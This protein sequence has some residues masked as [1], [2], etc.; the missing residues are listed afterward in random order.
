MFLC[1]D[2]QPLDSLL[3]C[4]V[5]LRHHL[6]YL[7]ATQYDIYF[8]VAHPILAPDRFEG[9]T[10]TMTLTERI[11]QKAVELG[12]DSVGIAP[13]QRAPH[14][15][16]YRNWLG[17][18]HQGNMAW[19]EK[20]PGRREDPRQVVDGAQ[21]VIAL[22]VSYFM[23]DP[24]DQLWND[25]SRGRIA[26]Y[27]WGPDYHDVLTPRLK[28]LSDFIHSESPG[29]ANRYYTDTGPVLEHE[30]AWQ[31]GQGFIGKHSL[32][33]HP[34]LGSYMFLGEIITTCELEPDTP[35]GN[36]GRDWSA[37]EGGGVGTCGSCR[38]CMDIC[39]THA[40]PSP[41]IL[42]SRLCLSY[43][44]IEL[45]EAIPEAL[46]P[47]LKNWVYGCDEC[48]EVCPWVKRY[49]SPGR[50]PFLEF[51]PDTS[52]PELLDLIQLDDEGFRKRFKGRAV[53]RTKRRGLLRNAAVAIGNWGAKDA[54]PIL[55]RVKEDKEILIREHIEWAI[56]KI[57]AQ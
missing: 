37:P 48:Q 9:H 13:A 25:P 18:G 8:S 4:S 17:E 3:N 30:V 16:T 41:Y 47:K 28:A 50:D 35:T 45:K 49:S 51:N 23:E 1:M 6:I 22:G 29:S 46:R 40:F 56:Q 31:A 42:N 55:N 7:H 36:E 43:L 32:F 33:I 10:L 14:A 57:T 52:I 12:F 2:I 11:K 21:C 15:D 54:L 38:R 20:Q 26:R 5:I 34:D 53:K 44:T 24:P 27:A 39:P 19:L